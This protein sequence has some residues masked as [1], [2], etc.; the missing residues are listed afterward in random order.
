MD[1]RNV[2]VAL[3]A[4]AFIFSFFT[5]QSTNQPMPLSGAAIRVNAITPPSQNQAREQSLV[6]ADSI[7]RCSSTDLLVI[8]RAGNVKP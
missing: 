5:F 6:P 7:I 4:A 3:V 1:S 2:L 8:E